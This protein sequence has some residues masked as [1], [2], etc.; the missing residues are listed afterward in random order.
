LAWIVWFLK[1]FN[2][3]ALQRGEFI[4]RTA[5]EVGTYRV[6]GKRWIVVACGVPPRRGRDLTGRY[7][8]FAELRKSLWQRG[9][10][11]CSFDPLL[12]GPV[13]LD[14]LQGVAPQTPIDAGAIARRQG[15]R[16]RGSERADPSEL[17]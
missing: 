10:G 5:E 2:W 17:A 3:A 7:L 9:R 6:N 8:S 13:P 14:C 1:S 12:P 16:W 4:T 15:M 11:V